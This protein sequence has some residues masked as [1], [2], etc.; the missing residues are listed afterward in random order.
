[1]TQIEASNPF[2]YQ[3]VVA[4]GLP[5]ERG[6]AHGRQ[7]QAKVQE[8]V[9]YYRR[10][11]KL[12][13]S[14]ELMEAIIQHVYKPALEQYYPS[15]LQEMQGTVPR[16]PKPTLMRTCWSWSFSIGICGQARRTRVDS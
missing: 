10:P 15:G 1:M 11:G 13:H 8:N 2:T 14:A 6:V 16:T 9:R 12:A 5:Y 7:A 3:H 4:R